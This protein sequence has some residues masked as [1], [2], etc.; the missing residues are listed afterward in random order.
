MQ[1][2]STLTQDSLDCRLTSIPMGS[3]PLTFLHLIQVAERLGVKYVWIDSLCIIQDSADDW[4]RESA[5]MS[6]VYAHACCTVAA[7]ASKNG[8]GGLF[9]NAG[10]SSDDSVR[11]RRPSKNGK[12]RALI[13]MKLQD[14]WE[15]MYSNG[16]FLHQRGW[17]LQERELSPRVL[18]FT[19]SQ[20]LW[21]CRTFKASE[22]W[23]YSKFPAGER[24]SDI[25]HRILD[26][27]QPKHK[28]TIFDAW[29]S[30]VTDYSTRA[31]TKDSDTLVALSG[32]ARR[33]SQYTN[34]KYFAGI[35]SGDFLRSLC[36]KVSPVASRR[37]AEFVA[38]SWSWASIKG[39]PVEFT[40]AKTPTAFFDEFADSIKDVQC[41]LATENPFGQ[42]VA[43]YLD[44]TARIIPAT[45]HEDTTSGP[46]GSF[47]GAWDF[48][49][50]NSRG[51][52][53]GDLIPD[54]D[55]EVIGI[56]FVHCIE[57]FEDGTGLVLVHVPYTTA[58]YRR[59]GFID[60]LST[61]VVL[62]RPRSHSSESSRDI[63]RLHAY[64][65][66]PF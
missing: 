22:G 37:R 21:E 54:D 44:I 57:L 47:R 8:A 20:V 23:P 43:G 17:T 46:Q 50:K 35:W 14:T 4:D 52:L 9:R 32:I 5:S 33:I 15:A 42:V 11:F 16:C 6:S 65:L 39:G 25:P 24:Q 31:L 51:R 59:I 64:T 30:L 41:A 40:E 48:H 45:V 60:E 26:T 53:I 36:W 61:I 63:Y 7:S 2:S 38:P 62:T 56:K 1:A 3:L 34:C 18:H 27:I 49:L 13:A 10:L 12:S 29:H 55:S 58:T 66:S 19:S 28:Q